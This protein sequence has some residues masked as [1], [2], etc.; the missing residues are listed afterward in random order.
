M[1]LPRTPKRGSP[2]A[3]GSRKLNG[4]FVRGLRRFTLNLPPVHSSVYR[5]AL[6][7]RHLYVL[8]GNG[9]LWV[10]AGFRLPRR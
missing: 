8:D 6:T 9:N 1:R 10:G 7:A 4:V 5:P 2:A 3:F